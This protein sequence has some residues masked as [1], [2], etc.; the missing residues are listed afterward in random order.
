MATRRLTVTRTQHATT[1][2][3]ED[4]SRDDEQ[5]PFAPIERG[6]TNILRRSLRRGALL[7]RLFHLKTARWGKEV[8]VRYSS[9][10]KSA[11]TFYT[12]SNGKEMVQRVY[13]RRGPS[14]PHPYNISEPVAGNYYPVNAMMSLDDGTHELAVLVDTSQAGASPEICVWQAEGLKDRR[15]PCLIL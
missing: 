13:N 14:Y 8:V 3:G 4:T 10:L 12:D 11:G 5:G 9:G 6:A 1:Y 2:C 15:E 7:L